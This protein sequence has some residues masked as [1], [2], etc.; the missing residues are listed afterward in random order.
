MR[1]DLD[2]KQQRVTALP[3]IKIVERTSLD[4]ILI[5]ACDGLWD[6]YSSEEGINQIREL[7]AEGESDVSLVAEEMLD[8]SLFK[9]MF[10]LNVP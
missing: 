9:G 6:V 5:L 1:S 2:D 10:F 3:D 4:D 8:L 7:F